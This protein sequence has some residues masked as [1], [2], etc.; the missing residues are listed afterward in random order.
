MLYWNLQSL[1]FAESTVVSWWTLEV[2]ARAT[3]GRGSGALHQVASMCTGL[4]IPPVYVK[5]ATAFVTVPS[6]LGMLR[7]TTVITTCLYLYHFFIIVIGP[8]ISAFKMMKNKFILKIFLKIY[9]ICMS[10]LPAGMHVCHVRVWC[11]QRLEER[12]GSPEIVVADGCKPLCGCWGLNV[13]P[14]YVQQ[15]FWPL[16][17]SPGPAKINFCCIKHLVYINWYGSL[18]RLT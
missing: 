7:S 18:S 1:K 10:V 2:L 5:E 9:F 8:W 14:L 6:T 11:L 17:H 3:P 15:M 12:D 16:S 13:S 4:H